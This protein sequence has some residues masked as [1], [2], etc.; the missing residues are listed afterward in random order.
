M[1]NFN[2]LHDLGDFEKV[3]R[4]KK[5]DIHREL[6]EMVLCSEWVCLA[7]F[8]RQLNL[9][10]GFY[11]CHLGESLPGSAPTFHVRYREPDLHFVAGTGSS[12]VVQGFASSCTATCRKICA[13]P[14]LGLNKE[15]TRPGGARPRPHDEGQEKTSSV[16]L[17]IPSR[18][19]E[20]RA[21]D[22]N[23]R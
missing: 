7:L 5:R 19:T 13:P 10:L 11:R 6:G 16:H 22:V 3:Q 20:M 12:V 2:P 1:Q 15:H 18:R 4:W 17:L 14:C 23:G 21:V 8:D 9:V